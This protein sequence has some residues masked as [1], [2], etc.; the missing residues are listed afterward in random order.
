MPIYKTNKSGEI[1]IDG[2]ESHRYYIT[3]DTDWSSNTARDYTDVNQLLKNSVG[4][5]YDDRWDPDY[6]SD[7]GEYHSVLINEDILDGAGGEKTIVFEQDDDLLVVMGK[8]NS[9]DSLSGD[10]HVKFEG[11]GDNILVIID[12]LGIRADAGVGDDYIM[13]AD[14]NDTI[15]AGNGDDFIIGGNGD[16]QI[17]GGEGNDTIEA[18]TLRSG[19]NDLVETG[20]GH[21][22]VM[23]GQPFLPESTSGPSDATI[24]STFLGSFGWATNGYIP[25]APDAFLKS[26]QVTAQYAI[27]GFVVSDIAEMIRGAETVDLESLGLHDDALTV[28]D[29]D[30]RYDILMFPSLDASRLK[31]E[32]TSDGNTPYLSTAYNDTSFAKIFLGED[33]LQAVETETGNEMT[34]A[35]IAAALNSYQHS[36]MDLS[37]S[38]LE[39]AGVDTSDWGID[40]EAG[41]KILGSTPGGHF[42][43][44][45]VGGDVFHL[46]SDKNDIFFAGS[47]IGAGT[48]TLVTDWVEY[49][50]SRNDSSRAFGFEGDDTLV[51]GNGNDKLYGG[52][53]DDL[54]IG[55][56]GADEFQGRD[57]FNTV[58]YEHANSAIS[59]NLSGAGYAN[60]TANSANAGREGYLYSEYLLNAQGAQIGVNDA[61]GDTLRYI[62]GIIGTAFDDRIE[63]TGL[64]NTLEGGRGADTLRGEEGVDTLSYISSDAA[65]NVNLQTQTASGGHAQ[66]D[67]IDGSFEI[68]IGSDYDDVLTGNAKDNTITGGRG[69]DTI[70]G[71]DGL[72]IVSYEA[73]SSAVYINLDES[74]DADQD[75][76]NDADGVW[77]GGLN[78]GDATNDELDSIEGLIGSSYD[79]RLVANSSA[80]VLK[81]GYG[82][83][84]LKGKGGDDTLYGGAG[85]DMIDG[86]NGFDIVSYEGSDSAVFI[87]INDDGDA[88]PNYYTSNAVIAA[89]GGLNGGHAYNDMI[90][91]IE[92]LIG[93]S[94]NDRLHGNDSGNYLSGGSGSDTL[95]GEGGDDTIEGGDGGDELWGGDGFD[96]VSYENS[97]AA[98]YIDLDGDGNASWNRNN[99]ANI[100]Y[101]GGV[102][103]GHG[104]GDTLYE[105]EGIIGSEHDDILEGNNSDNIIYGGDGD[106]R[107]QGLKGDD[108]LNGGD[109]ADTFVYRN[110]D[111][112]DTFQGFQN[113]VDTL[114]LSNFGFADFA[115]LSS[116]LNYSS[117]GAIKF[118]RFDFGGGDI[119]DVQGVSLSQL[120][121]DVI[122]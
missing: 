33:I 115:E 63:G 23:V 71:G 56:G 113:D 34:T 96:F 97:D 68:L 61:E 93:S 52:L 36:V 89:E 9:W 94:Y 76:R 12:D 92:G 65:V 8:W 88:F 35:D 4:S 6:F 101:N 62:N 122:L 43:E 22:V 1:D 114:D 13:S 87:N 107:L 100:A 19:D 25:T 103:G 99:T 24:A 20:S 67:D 15:Y 40:D 47:V 21:D 119:L 80:N 57:G 32:V 111:D 53:G 26:L 54:F 45:S 116:Y 120:E 28:L 38:G 10:Y 112:F 5:Y 74:G 72:D 121:N 58:S 59:V 39:N 109:G 44:G 104:S 18:G 79:D 3:L 98:V 46:G 51:G 70:S 117:D 42:T 55:F 110:G 11:D 2:S 75:N 7:R 60:W 17:F 49:S 95:K 77:V 85:E 73:S 29:F 78:G 108:I 118:T 50:R 69:G 27:I 31:V 81:G 84:T 91:D 83:D 66:G 82:N 30:P 105:F 16:D 106:D 90:T 14:G 37:K 64:D 86:G 48:G 41:W 102:N